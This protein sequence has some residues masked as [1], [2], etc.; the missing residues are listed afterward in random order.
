MGRPKN[1]CDTEQ[2]SCCQN[3]FKSALEDRRLWD[4]SAVPD[5]DFIDNA[6]RAFKTAFLTDTETDYNTRK[7]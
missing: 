5:D 7:A 4:S 2:F 1:R 6:E 3:V